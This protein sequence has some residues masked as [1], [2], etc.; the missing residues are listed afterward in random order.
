MAD[1]GQ[2]TYFLSL[3]NIIA[4]GNP[5]SVPYGEILVGYHRISQDISP[6]NK[7]GGERSWL[8]GGRAKRKKI[9]S[10]HKAAGSQTNED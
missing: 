1:S 9:R 4:H 3:D 10:V 8:S 2:N 5:M 7:E 6:R